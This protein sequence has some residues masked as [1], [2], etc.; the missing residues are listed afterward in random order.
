MELKTVKLPAPGYNS[1]RRIQA[2]AIQTQGGGLP[3]EVLNPQTCPLCGGGMVGVE[4]Q[5]RV[6]YKKCAD[7]GY[8]QPVFEVQNVQVDLGQVLVDVG[9]AALAGL[10]IG[11]LAYLVSRAL[12]K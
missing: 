9:K 4:A 6:G 12:S 3:L 10:A 1:L 11:A 5:L 8:G 7:C 2:R